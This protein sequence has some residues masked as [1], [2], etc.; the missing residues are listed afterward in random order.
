MENVG[1]RRPRPTVLVFVFTCAMWEA[2]V[3]P[4]NMN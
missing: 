4:Y 2:A 1:V 3:L